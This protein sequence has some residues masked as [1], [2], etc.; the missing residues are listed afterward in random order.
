MR[1]LS[2]VPVGPLAKLRESSGENDRS[3]AASPSLVGTHTFARSLFLSHKESKRIKRRNTHALDTRSRPLSVAAA[4]WLQGAE[5]SGATLRQR[6]STPAHA[7]RQSL[8]IRNPN[9]NSATP[10]DS[11]TSANLT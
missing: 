4:A 11:H 9:N 1:N 2:D 7:P 3:S 6:A 10:A 5:T 8:R